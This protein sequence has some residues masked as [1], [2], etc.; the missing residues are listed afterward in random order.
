MKFLMLYLGA[1]LTMNSCNLSNAQTLELK[2]LFTLF[3]C[4]YNSKLFSPEDI[5]NFSFSDSLRV[6]SDYIKQIYQHDSLLNKYN[7]DNDACYLY[8]KNLNG[9]HSLLLIHCYGEW[10][11]TIE[12]L[13]YDNNYQLHGFL[14]LAGIGGG[15]SESY[16]TRGKFVKDSVFLQTMELVEWDVN[17]VDGEAAIVRQDTIEKIFIIN[18]K[19]S[20]S[21]L[22]MESEKGESYQR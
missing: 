14:V 21:E 19:G 2:D 15:L 4:S 9:K 22:N 16:K 20:V 5:E 12:L 3:Q 11:K 10:Y 18:Q 17:S 8:G 6:R 1:I 7:F 13:T